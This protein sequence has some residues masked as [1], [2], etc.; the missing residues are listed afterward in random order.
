MK[1]LANLGL[2]LG[3]LLAARARAET[4]PPASSAVKGKTVDLDGHPLA[5]VTVQYYG[6]RS[7]G[8]NRAELEPS[9]QTTSDANGEFQMPTSG[10]AL[11]QGPVFLVAR[12]AGLAPAWTQFMVGMSAEAR[13]VLM[14]SS[15][16]AGQVVDEADKPVPGA[17]VSVGAAYSETPGGNVGRSFNFLNDRPARDLFTIKAGADGRFRIE[18]F[19]TNASAMLVAEA[20]GKALRAGG[21]DYF[22]PDT[23]PFRAGQED[24]RLVLEPAGSV[25]GKIVKAEAGE[26][27]TA[28]ISVLPT[29][30]GV[31]FLSRVPQKAAADGTF[32]LTDLRA[33]AYRVQASFGTNAVPD[34]VADSVPVTV[35]SGQVSR[36]VELQAVRGGLLEVAL[37][38]SKD[39]KPIDEAAVNAYRD[40][41]QS[42]AVS[43]NGVAVLRLPAGDYQV[44]A[45]KHGWQQAGAPAI[46][47]SG[48]TNRVEVELAPARNLAGIVRLPNGQPA[49]NVALQVIGNYSMQEGNLR[50]GPDGKFDIEWNMQNF[51]GNN[52]TPCLLV[53][54]PEHNLALAQDLDDEIDRLDLRL[55]PALSFVVRVECDGK[56]L[57]N[58]T[59]GLLFRTGN[60]GMFLNGMSSQ[61][62]APGKIEVLAL[63]P[64]RRYGIQ[65]SA[66]GYGA[67][68]IDLAQKSDDATRVELDSV[69]L[70]R[71]DRKL[72]GQLVDTDDKPVSGATVQ[73]NGDGQPNASVR[74]DRDGRFS[75]DV[76]EGTVQ[77]FA[78]SQ[79]AFGNKSAEA[80]DTNVVLKLGERSMMFGGAK[81]QKIKGVV[82]DANGKP[83][84]DA[85]VRVLP[86][87]MPNRSKTD[88]NGAFST[89][90][91]VQ[92][93]QRQNGHPL[94][95]VR[96]RARNQAVAQEISDEETNV[97]VQLQPALT[98]K[99]Q[100]VGPDTKPLA[101]AQVNLIL[102]SARMGSQVDDQPLMTDAQGGFT[103]A[104]L[105][106]GQEFTLFASRD[107][108]GQKRRKIELDPETNVVQVPPLVLRLANQLIAGKV[109]DDK[110]KPV[111][112][113]FVQV[114]SDD[115]PQANMQ[116]DSK[117]RFK[118]KVCEGEVRLFANSQMG[119]AQVNVQAGDTNV[120]LLLAERTMRM[121]S[122]ARRSTPRTRPNVAALKGKPLP[123]LT[124]LG[125]AADAA[126]PGKPVLLCLVDVQQRL[127]RRFARL[128]N[129]QHETLREQGV[130]LLAAQTASAPDEKWDDWK[131]AYQVRFPVSRLPEKTEA[132]KWASSLETLPWLILVDK[133]GVVTDEGF[134]LEELPARLR[135]LNH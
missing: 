94:L 91:V 51:G 37:R 122:A 78:N 103:F 8:G 31:S 63:P 42:G 24:I 109:L 44:N 113:A 101:N 118:F 65:I 123:D 40:R 117:G 125:F 10:L 131:E 112:G 18:G 95:V 67:K 21:P 25:E 92:P 110:D 30:P 124:S 116:T 87:E 39:S 32:R 135:E 11:P 36:G 9:R 84:A 100:V 130:T 23:M 4:T 66:P 13:L 86:M 15:S 106:V 57:T 16:L 77:L 119:F 129:E 50:T 102:Q 47:Q 97:T 55:A 17:Q 7:L 54:D 27:P 56:P 111:S 49:T 74:T 61:T 96:H 12:K 105:P 75:F 14:P 64:G 68:F 48:Q 89:S 69:E 83:V 72:A 126:P 85:E 34:W 79:R 90:Y 121:P 93:W 128:L 134:P 133:N 38:G 81:P 82:T 3:V 28:E 53:R 108:Y 22:S 58:A 114:S 107:G 1:A 115:Q 62:S 104:A 88:A 33:G 43:S 98:I 29:G 41:F 45:S 120:V 2:A 99:G 70:R 127:S 73:V 46:V 35:D 26:I 59:A 6:Y 19:P 52:V 60:M 132:S 5:G 80:G 71:A 20:P 76:C